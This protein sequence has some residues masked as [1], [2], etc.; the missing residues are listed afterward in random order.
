MEG[1]VSTWLSHYGSI[2]F[3]GVPLVAYFCQAWFVY[4]P[5]HRYGLMLMMFAY[6]VAIVGQYLDTRGI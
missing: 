4:R 5:G 3:L 1:S 6:A 2:V